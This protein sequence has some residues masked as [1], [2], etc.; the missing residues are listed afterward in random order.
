M[1]VFPEQNGNHDQSDHGK[2]DQHGRFPVRVRVSE[3]AESRASVLRMGQAKKP[4][5]DL[6]MRIKRDTLRHD[7]LRPAVKQEND[8]SDQ[9][10]KGARG[11]LGH[12]KSWPE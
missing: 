10:T 9:E 5:Y 2:H 3:Q 6:D 4:C 11:F 12:P 8:E 1:V 7:V